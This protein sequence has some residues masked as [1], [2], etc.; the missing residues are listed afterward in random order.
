LAVTLHAEGVTAEFDEE[1]LEDDD[2][3]G[4]AHFFREH[5]RVEFGVQPGSESGEEDV[6]HQR[7]GGDVKVGR[8]DVLPWWRISGG[9]KN[10]KDTPKRKK[11]NNPSI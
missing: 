8:V 1:A 7:H 3:D 2:R 6:G 9:Y 5:F 11:I 10:Q 4:C